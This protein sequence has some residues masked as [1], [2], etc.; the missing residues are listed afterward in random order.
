MINE[1]VMSDNDIQQEQ[2]RVSGKP[3]LWQMEIL[4][5]AIKD[6]I[7]VSNL[8]DSDVSIQSCR[9]SIQVRVS[10]GEII[11]CFFILKNLHLIMY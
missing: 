11:S 5:T 3:P 1:K 8:N 2:L 6:T 7:D 10:F 9:N 4:D